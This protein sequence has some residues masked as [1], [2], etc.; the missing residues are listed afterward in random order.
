MREAWTFW[1]SPNFSR[2]PSKGTFKSAIQLSKKA[3]RIDREGTP[4]VC[5]PTLFKTEMKSK[6][7][8]R[9]T[10]NEEMEKRTTEV[11]G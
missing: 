1:V 2:I 4:S 3:L 8:T 9:L 5:V 11:I 6:L 7:E 10:A